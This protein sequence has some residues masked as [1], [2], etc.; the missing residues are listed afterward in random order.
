M[1][2]IVVESTPGTSRLDSL[3]VFGWPVWTKEASVFPWHYDAQET[4][5]FLEGEVEVIPESGEPVRMGKGD[6]AV[7]PKGLSCTWRITKDVRKHYRFG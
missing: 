7:F 4:C 2:N 6:L 1:L 3:G 5:Y